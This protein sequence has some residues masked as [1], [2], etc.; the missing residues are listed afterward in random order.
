MFKNRRKNLVKIIYT[1]LY[2]HDKISLFL[3]LLIIVSAMLVIWIT[4]QTRYMISYREA[5]LLKKHSLEYEQNNLIF[6][7]EI[8]TNYVRI[9]N[10]AL[11]KL[12][13]CYIDPLLQDAWDN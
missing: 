2:L 9:E 11:N 13:M 7:K 4:Y 12:H 8:L 1:D 3:L 5:F 10:I 6:E